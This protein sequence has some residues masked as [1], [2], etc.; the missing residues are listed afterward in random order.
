MW[1]AIRSDTFE[2]LVA[3]AEEV[4]TAEDSLIA[5]LPVFAEMCSVPLLNSWLFQVLRTGLTAIF[6]G[7][8]SDIN[9]LSQGFM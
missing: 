2:T 8:P 3:T 1:Q 6:V 4:A 7:G 5:E 9:Q